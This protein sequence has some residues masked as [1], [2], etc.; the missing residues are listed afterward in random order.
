[1]FN[2]YLKAFYG[3]NTPKTQGF[4]CLF[5]FLGGIF[6]A[7]PDMT[8]VAQALLNYASPSSGEAYRDRQLTTNFEF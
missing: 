4:L 1:M 5:F 6:V 7:N 3:E 8:I 2:R